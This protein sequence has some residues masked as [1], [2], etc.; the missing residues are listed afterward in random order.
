MKI[1]AIATMIGSAVGAIVNFY[2]DQNCHDFIDQRNIFDSTCATGVGGY[3]S[4]AI[5]VAGGHDQT[6]TAYS[7]DACAGHINS[8]VGATGPLDTC[9][10][11]IDSSASGGI[12][13]NAMSSAL[14]CGPLGLLVPFV[15]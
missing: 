1:F 14:G 15:P 4:Y 7:R 8:C 10:L 6:L 2:S 3:Q 11:A 5:I 12:G 13:S 9:F